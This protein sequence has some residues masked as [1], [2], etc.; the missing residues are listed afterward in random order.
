MPISQSLQPG[1]ADHFVVRI[2][3]DKSARFD[4]ALSLKDASGRILPL[5]DV[6]LDLF[7]PRSQAGYAAA[8]R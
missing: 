1:K 2:A 3:S 7:V 6:H 8:G 5:Q 4:L